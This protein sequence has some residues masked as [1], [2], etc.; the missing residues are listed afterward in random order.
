MGVSFFRGTFASSMAHGTHAGHT[1][2]KGRVSALPANVERAA[3]FAAL[4]VRDLTDD[5]VT[6]K[7]EVLLEL[8]N[9]GRS[10]F[11]KRDP[12]TKE[13]TSMNPMEEELVALWKELTGVN[14]Q[15]RSFKTRREARW[16]KPPVSFDEGD[17]G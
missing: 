14:L 9:D 2:V 11:S 13:V 4:W 5:W 6:V 17:D 8:D 12:K 7:E 15:L 10:L 3:R 1:D 16:W